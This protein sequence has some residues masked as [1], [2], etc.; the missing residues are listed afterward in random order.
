MMKG[1][2]EASASRHVM[3][4]RTTMVTKG[5][6]KRL[7]HASVA[8]DFFFFLVSFYT[9]LTTFLVVDFNY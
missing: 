9:L 2:R 6:K 3:A 4:W 8:K 1:A 5:L 7:R